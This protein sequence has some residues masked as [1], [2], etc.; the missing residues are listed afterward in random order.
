M[1]DRVLMLLVSF[2]LVI[3]GNAAALGKGAEPLVEKRLVH[4]AQS[5]TNL[6]DPLFFVDAFANSR[7]Q[8]RIYEYP[9]R[10]NLLYPNNNMSFFSV[11][12]DGWIYHNKSDLSD[13]TLVNSFRWETHTHG[14]CRFR[15]YENVYVR[16]DIT[17]IREKV[18]IRLTFTNDD[19]Y[20][21]Y[22]EARYLLDTM[23]D[24]NDGAWLWQENLGFQ[25]N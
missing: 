18:H 25:G 11:N 3:F 5:S 2:S 19:Y 4:A 23:I 9:S 1:R 17:I 7:G 10:R 8:P 12:I 14:W 24:T 21:H 15:S 6:S 20:S 22:V 13:F 16:E